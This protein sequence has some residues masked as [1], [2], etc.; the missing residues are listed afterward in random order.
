MRDMSGKVTHQE[1]RDGLESLG[2]WMEYRYHVHFIGIPIHNWK[3]PR[4][5]KNFFTCYVMNVVLE[6]EGF[7]CLKTQ[8]PKDLNIFIRIL[9][10]VGAKRTSLL[11]QNTLESLMKNLPC[12]QDKCTSEYYRTFEREKVWLKL[13]DYVSQ[14]IYMRYLKRAQEIAKAGGSI[15]DYK[16]WQLTSK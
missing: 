6:S 5:E 2:E 3:M 7:R 12:D 10:K 8:N 4:K 9:S 11:V 15:F 16:E 1:A 13:L 14:S